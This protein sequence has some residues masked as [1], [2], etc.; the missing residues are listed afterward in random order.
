MAIITGAGRGIGHATSLKFGR[1]GAIVISCDINADQ[2]QQA[3]Q[4]V[5]EAGGEALACQIDVRDPA[6]IARMVE[7]VVRQI[8]ADRLPGEQR[9]HRPGRD[10]E[11][12][13]RGAVRRR[14]RN[15][16]EGRLQL[17]ARGGGHHAEAAVRGHSQ[18]FFHR[19]HLRQFRPDQLRRQQVRRHRHGQDLGQGTGPQG[20][21]RQR[22]LPGIR[23][24]ARSSARFRRRC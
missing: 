14:D 13:E 11:E 20:H 8:R 22:R 2:A 7:T 24:D 3:A 15:Q 18:R 19:R 6:S 23:L 1:E 12:H 4:D 21:P 5:I 17:H 10:A 16:P 9:R